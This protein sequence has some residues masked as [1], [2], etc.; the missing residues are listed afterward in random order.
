MATCS[1]STTPAS[2]GEPSTSHNR[3]S[4]KRYRS[5]SKDFHRKVVKVAQELSDDDIENIV[6]LYRKKLG[7][8]RRSMTALSILEKLQEK[9]VFSAGDVEPLIELLRDDC[10][11]DDLA[12]KFEQYRNRCDTAQLRMLT[13]KRLLRRH[14]LSLG[15]AQVRCMVLLLCN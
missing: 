6:Y 14:S 13:V 15:Q 12:T 4:R 3:R 9:G 1:A 2:S 11:R 10:G 8:K 7:K 5:P